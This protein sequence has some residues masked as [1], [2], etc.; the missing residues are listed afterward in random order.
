MCLGGGGLLL[1]MFGILAGIRSEKPT[2]LCGKD[3]RLIHHCVSHARED[4]HLVVVLHV[5]GIVDVVQCCLLAGE[6]DELLG[7]RSALGA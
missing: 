6:A 5:A 1:D 7:V 2:H 4:V 3:D